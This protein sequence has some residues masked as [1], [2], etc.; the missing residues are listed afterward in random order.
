MRAGDG[1]MRRAQILGGLLRLHHGGPPLGERSLLAALRRET[2]ELI[3]RVAKPFGLAAGA[4]D[5]R[6]MRLDRGF[7]LAPLIPAAPDIRGSVLK[8]AKRVE[9][10]AM[11]CRLDEGAVIMLAVNFDQSGA[12]RA[13]HLN[14]HRLI[15]DEGA[16]AAVGEL[17]TADNQFVTGAQI[18]AK[19]VGSEHGAR[20]MVVGD[21]ERRGHLPLLGALTHQR[22]VA[23][24]AQRK[25]KGVEQDR[26]AGAGLAGQRSKT[27]AKVDV[28]AIDQNDITNGKAD[29][30]DDRRP[31]SDGG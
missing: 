2:S 19:I 11:R 27:G 4:L 15:V 24:R 21:V 16:G 10:C 29:E 20:R 9:Q 6:P 5:I 12:E 28:Q 31:M 30:H 23:T 1:L 18:C 13:Q 3:D 22:H 14:A 25:R 7:A 26:F 8:A 17:H